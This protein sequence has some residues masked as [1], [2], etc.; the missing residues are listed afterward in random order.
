MVE[1]I[2][3][4][5]RALRLPKLMLCSTNDPVVK[6]TWHHLNFDFA[7]DEELHAWNIPHE[8]LVYLQGTTQV[9]GDGH[10]LAF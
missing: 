3:D 2:E 4:I 5:A 1:A 6:S 9:G 8:D 7:T 10:S